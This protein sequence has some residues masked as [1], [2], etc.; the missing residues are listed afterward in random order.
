[1]REP[2]PLPLAGGPPERADAARNRTLLLRAAADILAEGGTQ[3]LTMDALAQRAGVGKG[4]VF[5]RF[6]SRSGL[7]IALLN[8]TE[9][10][11]QQA[12]LFGP[13]PLGPGA[14]PQERI[15]AFG[16]AQLRLLQTD[17][18]IRR[19]ASSGAGQYSVPAYQLAAQHIALQLTAAGL[20][21]GRL[22]A[23]TMLAP[24]NALLVHHQISELGYSY[25][26]IAAN[27][28]TQTRR[29]LAARENTQP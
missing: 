23:D 29:I 4:T 3:A 24:L 13:P 14:A 28:E 22:L 25:A 17:G 18:E 19:A 8:H 5:R 20:P 21:G 9:Q 16:H 6:G 1:M 15:I 2:T 26:D 12:F 7:L 27:W 10:E 11:F